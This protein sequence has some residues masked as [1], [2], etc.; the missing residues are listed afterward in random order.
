MIETAEEHAILHRW[1]FSEALSIGLTVPK[2]INENF[3]VDF[4]GSRGRPV[5]NAFGNLTLQGTAVCC[6][7]SSASVSDFHKKLQIL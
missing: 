3:T 5:L 7:G 2:E 4:S 6:R 1:D